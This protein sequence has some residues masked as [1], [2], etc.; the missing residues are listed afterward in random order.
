[1]KILIIE[2]DLNKLQSVEDFLQKYFKQ[3]DLLY[4]LTIKHSYQSGLENVL[5]NSYDLLLLDMS[6]PNFDIDEN[7]DIGDPLSKGGELILY[8]MDAMCIDL[9][10]IIIT[11]HEDFDGVSLES[12]N[13]D[14]KDKFSDIYLNY[15]FYNS[16]ESNWEKELE[17]ILNGVID[18]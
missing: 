16:I 11:Q 10:T 17:K 7:N 8:E 5:T 3:K 12:I 9:K 6:L 2:D 15:V 14:Y 18:A 13:D 4:S 1:M